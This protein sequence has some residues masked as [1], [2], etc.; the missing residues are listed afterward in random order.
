MSGGGPIGLTEIFV[1]LLGI[2]GFGF[3]VWM[4]I[5]CAQNDSLGSEKII[6]IL[7]I[8]LGGCI[9]ASIYFF[10]KKGR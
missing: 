9:G 5:D 2:L 8:L 6:W 7:I 4:I 10:I 1:L 3:W